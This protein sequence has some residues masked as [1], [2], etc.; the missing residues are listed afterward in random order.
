MIDH[1]LETTKYLGLFISLGAFMI[2]LKLNKK[3][4]YAFMN[5][6]LIGTILV[7]GLILALDIEVAV[8][9]KSAQVL[10]DLLTPAT[11]CLAVPVYRQ[12]KIL[13]DNSRV[14]LISCIAG[15]I[16]GLITII[17]LALVL[18]MSKITTLSTLARSITMAIALDTTELIGGIVGIIVAGVIFAGIFG[19]VVSSLIFRIFKIEEPIA[20]GLALGAASHAM[21]TAESLKAGELQGAMSSL[22]MVV[23]GVMMVGLVPLAALFVQ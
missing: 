13:R 23:S 7:I 9:Q 10:S 1:L 16:S 19:T 21:G 14:V 4:P 17:G 12:F 5:P 3:Y 20:K 11:I 2:G 22:A 15:M 18:Q 6:L 8:F